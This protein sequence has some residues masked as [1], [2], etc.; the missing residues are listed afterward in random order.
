MGAPRG[1]TPTHPP[2][3]AAR[4]RKCPGTPGFFSHPPLH[5]SPEGPPVFV[6][7]NRLLPR[8]S[9]GGPGRP[10]YPTA[11]LL[12]GA[13]PPPPLST[14]PPPPPGAASGDADPGEDTRRTHHPHTSNP[15]PP[16]P[17]PAA[18]PPPRG[19]GGAPPRPP[20]IHPGLLISPSPPLS[21]LRPL[22]LPLLPPPPPRPPPPPPPRVSSL[23]SSTP[24]RISPHPPQKPPPPPPLRGGSPPLLLPPGGGG[25][26]PPPDPP[27]A[28]GGGGPGGA[29]L[30]SPLLLTP[31]PYPPGNIR[32]PP[33]PPTLQT[34]C[35]PP[36]SHPFS[37]SPL[38]KILCINPS[39]PPPSAQG[40]PLASATF[41]RGV[42]PPCAGASTSLPPR[43]RGGD[44]YG[45]PN[46]PR[47]D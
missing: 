24:P 26:C 45:Y 8:P 27:G 17:P 21:P 18:P 10:P 43:R 44:Q 30:P 12:G 39:T 42:C 47:R 46:F 33:D 29:P 35:Y 14:P 19:P 11:P 2:L 41:Y 37:L 31:P 36:P 34:S 32:F 22:P 15:P 16:P 20:L 3:G 1:A 23:K 5:P 6:A 9:R 28:R 7:Y 4:R 40:P 25:G 38:S 13:L